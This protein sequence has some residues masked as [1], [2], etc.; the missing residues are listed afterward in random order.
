MRDMRRLI[1]LAISIITVSATT[2]A[3]ESDSK[4]QNKEDKSPSLN[5]SLVSALQLR[6]IGPAFM[7]GRISDI[8]IDPQDRSTW[9]V[10]AASGGVWKTQQRRDHL[11]SDFR[12]LRIVFDRLCDG[13]SAEPS[14]GVGGDGREQQSAERGVW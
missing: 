11:D 3:Q 5:S 4:E 6:G 13:R 7:S 8:A 1:L 14:R 2:V 9:Y 12:Q 10:A